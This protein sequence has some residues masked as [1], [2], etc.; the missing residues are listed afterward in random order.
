MRLE[1]KPMA[2]SRNRIPPG[3]GLWVAAAVLV[4]SLSV[5]SCTDAQS[6]PGYGGYGADQY[7]PTA[8]PYVAGR[9][10]EDERDWLRA[11]RRERAWRRREQYGHFEQ[12]RWR[13]EVLRE[14]QAYRRA[15]LLQ[16]QRQ[17]QQQ[18]A[19]RAQQEAYSRALLAKREEYNRALLAQQQAAAAAQRR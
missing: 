5:A 3:G 13:Q 6:S 11:E 18:A 8:P 14:Q 1:N 15:Q 4:A 12:Q 16:H 7:A 17:A 19:V 10:Y 9:W 2:M